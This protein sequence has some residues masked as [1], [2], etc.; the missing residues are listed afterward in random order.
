MRL[1]CLSDI[2]GKRIVIEELLKEAGRVDTIVIS[3]DIT[4]AG[5]YDR[6]REIL[7][8]LFD[9]GLEVIAIPGNMDTESVSQYL[10]D[11]RANIE[12]HGKVIGGVGFFGVGGSNHSIF[13]TPNE[14][15]GEMLSKLLET[16]YGEIEYREVKVLVSHAPPRNTKLDRSFAGTHVGSDEIRRFLET[17]EI[18]LC[19]CGHIH[20]SS[21]ED[22]IK[23]TK[24]VNVGPYKSGYYCIIDIEFGK[25][26]REKEKEITIERRR[27]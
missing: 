12:G 11:I 23:G 16:G 1:L 20:E 19:I 9:L 5:N 14:K 22:T 8:P 2:H 17:K 6:A 7:E 10:K 21:G 27:L 25:E 15:P 3:G 18:D 13:R 26:D 24:C 4:H